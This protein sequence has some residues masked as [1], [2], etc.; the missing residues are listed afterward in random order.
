M[1]GSFSLE[2]DKQHDKEQLL[3]IIFLILLLAFAGIGYV[4]YARIHNQISRVGGT[5]PVPAI[6]PPSPVVSGHQLAKLYYDSDTW[7]YT[8]DGWHWKC[9]CGTKASVGTRTSNGTEELAMSA[10]K[11]HAKLY[12]DAGLTDT[13]ETKYK[14]LEKKHNDYVDACICKNL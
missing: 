6:R 12:A 11:R 14:E 4:G 2:E 13:W 10:W 9:S 1:S 5:T 7:D 8:T 3:D